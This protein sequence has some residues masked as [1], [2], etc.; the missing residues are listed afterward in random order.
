V[1]GHPW[2]KSL[3]SVRFVVS[4]EYIRPDVWTS[5]FVFMTKHYTGDQN[6]YYETDW[7]R[8]ARIREKRQCMHGFGG[9]GWGEPEGT[10]HLEDLRLVVR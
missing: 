10:N 5:I 8:V 7:Q 4:L 6:K 3:L 2:Y 1:S 9:W